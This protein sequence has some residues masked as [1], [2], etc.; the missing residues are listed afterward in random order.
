MKTD[1]KNLTITEMEHYLE[2]LE[3]KKFRARQIFGWIYKGA[4]SFDE[5]TD[6][7]KE[8][9][10]KLDDNAEMKKLGILKVQ[11][12][13]KDGTRK[14]LFG[15]EDGNSIES[16]FMK[17]KF[18]NTVCISSQAGCRMGCSFCAS[19]INGL[20][21]NLTAGEMADQILSVEKDTGEKVS[22]IVVM[23]TGEP[24][25]NYGN[26]S[27]FIEII[28]EKDGLNIGMRSITVSTCGMIPKMFELAKDFPQINLAVSL[29]APN[30]SIRNKLMPI[31][32]RYP[33]EELLKACSQHIASTGRRITFEYAL[34][35]GLND[36]DR[37]AEELAAKLRGINCHVNL[38]PL[39]RVAET[40][41]SGTERS[42]VE[43]FHD[44]LEKRGI[45][46]TIRRELGSDI[47]AACGQLRL[48]NNE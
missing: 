10:R 34:V 5:M 22:N 42:V 33:M 44:L 35:K 40:G 4:D 18:G 7:S 8:L 31:S 1:L 29:H 21:R 3:E 27:K 26:L 14:Y 46:V 38:I 47:D 23:G 39:N 37:N 25:D 32:K 2:K 13:G 30:D 19:A 9:R 28:H 6:L 48:K 17:Y 15:L 12:S 11:N 36:S 41:L 24:L 20:K 43:R 16:V 45:Q